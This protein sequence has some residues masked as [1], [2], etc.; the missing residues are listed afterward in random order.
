[1][2]NLKKCPFCACESIAVNNNS[3]G[4]YWCSCRNCN[5]QVEAVRGGKEAIIQWNTRLGELNT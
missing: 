5:C 4:Y 1:M 3:S 2:D